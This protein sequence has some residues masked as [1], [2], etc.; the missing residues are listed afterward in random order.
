MA[1][2]GHVAI[3]MA[4]GRRFSRHGGG[5]HLLATM[6]I[7][8]V[9][10]LLPDVDVVAFAL[11][12]PYAAPWGHRGALHSLAVALAVGIGATLASSALRVSPARAARIG[13]YVTLVVAS[14][15]LLD[16]MT[17]GGKGVALLWPLT[18]QR[19][20][21]SWRPIP[22]APIGAGFLSMRGLRVALVEFF[23]LSPV[24]AYALFARPANVDRKP[25][26]H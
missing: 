21:F 5:G 9:L 20:F 10:S 2:I 14:H 1:S 4:A 26:P 22:V 15:G 12:I 7:F 3:G 19:F 6:A 13:A 18:T 11:R 25:S 24:F 23:E 8:S 17:D 16:A